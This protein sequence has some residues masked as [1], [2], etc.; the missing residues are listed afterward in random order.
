MKQNNNIKK[1]IIYKKFSDGLEYVPDIGRINTLGEVFTPKVIVDKMIK[2]LK[3]NK[4]K[5]NATIL[6]PASGHGNFG[7]EILKYKLMKVIKEMKNDGVSEKMWTR[8]YEIRSL[9]AISSLYSNDIDSLNIEEIKNR[10]SRY[11]INCYFKY[12]HSNSKEIPV[13][14]DIALANILNSNTILGNFIKLSDNSNIKFHFYFRENKTF[15]IFHAIVSINKF[16]NK[17]K[18]TSSLFDDDNIIV[19]ANKFSYNEWNDKKILDNYNIYNINKNKMTNKETTESLTTKIINEIN[20]KFGLSANHKFDFII[21]NPPYQIAAGNRNH[22]IY[23]DFW[24]LSLEMARNVCMI[25]PLGWQKSSGH[26]SGSSR[27]YLLRNDKHIISV[28]NFT[29]DNKTS[30]RLFPTASTGGVN[31][32]L[33]NETYNNNGYVDFCVNGEKMQKKDL[34]DI[35]D[36]SEQTKIIFN[37]LEEY[38]NSNSTNLSEK[39]ANMEQIISGRNPCGLETSILDPNRKPNELQ[40][41]PFDGAIKFWGCDQSDNKYKWFYITEK[42]NATILKNNQKKTKP[43][44]IKMTKNN[45]EKYKV[46]WPKSGAWANWRDAGSIDKCPIIKPHEYFTDTFINIYLNSEDECNNFITYFRTYLYRFCISEC[47]ISHNACCIV[48]KFVPN[49]SNIENP[50]THKIGW[51]SKW[52]NDDLKKLFTTITPDEWEYIKTQALKNDN[53]RDE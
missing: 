29:E 6:E 13:H 34:T 44:H 9:L 52:T 25:F 53:N 49:L 38:I 46:I 47:A 15:N 1:S 21:S 20:K 18:N 31:I 48:H 5:S 50:R 40:F 3:I 37:K 10:Y 36:Y 39:K 51:N 7:I 24:L 42:F 30:V 26:A 35:Q 27:H 4:G 45:E 8:E 11:V 2:M 41:S 19:Y 33:W 16:I 22:Q 32:V 43:I 14:Y 17:L 28:E 12:S 23:A